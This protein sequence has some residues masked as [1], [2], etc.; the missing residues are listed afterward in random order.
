MIVLFTDFGLAGPYMGQMRAVLKRIAPTA[1]VVTSFSDAPRQNPR[2]S[3]YLLAAYAPEFPPGTVFLCVVDPGVGGKRAGGFLEADGRWY[4]GPENGLLSVVARRA[5]NGAV[6]R[7]LDPASGPVSP[8]FHGRD[9]FAPAAAGLALG[10]LPDSTEKPVQAVLR[11]DWPDDLAEVIYI[12]DFG[13]AMTG[14]RAGT[15]DEQTVVEIGNTELRRAI[16]FSDVPEGSGFWYENSNGL[17]EIAVNC[18]SA[19][20]SLGLKLGDAL[21]MK[22][23]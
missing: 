16:T 9:I 17:L 19:A 21:H 13:N 10:R 23:L 8:T 14:V 1:E 2:A 15:V 20:D 18:G 6:W 3:A 4:V 7:E 12:D 11:P 22:K 5:V